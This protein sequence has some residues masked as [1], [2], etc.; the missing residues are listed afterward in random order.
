MLGLEAYSDEARGEVL[1]A[2]DVGEDAKG[3]R[4]VDF[5]GVIE[6]AGEDAVSEDLDALSVADGGL[7]VFLDL[8]E[9]MLGEGV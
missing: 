6:N 7:A 4:R 5:A 3:E 2:G 9:V 1:D 8:A